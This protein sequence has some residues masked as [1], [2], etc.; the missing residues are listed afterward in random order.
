MAHSSSSATDLPPSGASNT[1]GGSPKR[2]PRR[3][4]LPR[5]SAAAWR[6]FMQ[7]AKPYWLGDQRKAAW[8][9]LALMIVLMLC[10]T[11]LAVLLNDKTGELTSALAARDPSR[12]WLAVRDSLI[13]LAFA[14]PVYAFY[15]YMRDAFSNHWR[16]WLTGRF[17]DGY[18][19]GRKY[20][21]IGGAGAADIDNP[22]QRISE[23]INTFTGRSTHF[24]LL[25]LG[26]AM[27]L[28]AFSAVLW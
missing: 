19:D 14:V 25:M 18:L 17:L 8:G 22:D 23:D 12:F 7:I 20:Y 26:S 1:A 2:K 16:R 27:Q 4:R 9:L 24:S 3:R 15:Y 21:E 13:V 11:Q 5:L 6:Q 28:I 10:E